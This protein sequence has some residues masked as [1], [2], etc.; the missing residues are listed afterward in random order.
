MKASLRA[1]RM[2]RNHKKLSQ[3][4]KLNLV[5]LMD[6]FTILV[7]FLMVNNGDVEVL[8][9]DKNVVLPE[10]VSEQRPDV[11]LTIKVSEQA[12]VV[13]GRQI[14]TIKS[15]LS[16]SGNSIAALRKELAYHAERAPK[17]T[18]NEQKAGR[19]IIIMG[20]ETMPYKILKRVMSTCAESD[21]RDI[22]LAVNSIPVVTEAETLQVAR[23]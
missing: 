23:R 6:I 1:R 11:A 19:S 9:S 5:A 17:L 20:N 14:A 13:Q 7:F 12:I 22:S 2:A 4:P 18:K 10:S 8:Q 3:H 16:Q 15:A 21:Y